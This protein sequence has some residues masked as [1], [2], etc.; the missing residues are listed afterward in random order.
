MSV[1]ALNFFAPSR[2]LSK[3]GLRDEEPRDAER[4]AS[5]KEIHEYRNS[6]GG[7]HRKHSKKRYSIC[8]VEYEDILNRFAQSRRK[9]AN[10]LASLKNQIGHWERTAGVGPVLENTSISD[11]LLIVNSL[12]A[13]AALDQKRNEG[14]SPL[15]TLFQ[16][17]GHPSSKM[18][19]AAP[20]AARR[21]SLAVPK[22]SI[23]Q[24]GRNRSFSTN[25]RF[26]S[27]KTR[28]DSIPA[29]SN[30]QIRRLR[31]ESVS[32]GRPDSSSRLEP[33][34][35]TAQSRRIRR[36]SVKPVPFNAAMPEI[37]ISGPSPDVNQ[38]RHPSRFK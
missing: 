1:A 5:A 16:N 29:L 21:Y 18:A 27:A 37:I 38:R 24:A 17:E 23:D 22:E 32:G 3:S 14:P 30:P 20:T 13:N 12:S 11:F 2:Q 36:F 9:E 19:R 8:D 10:I 15:F 26:S 33:P 34:S 31:S 28:T 35:T 25:V 6:K 4:G 7:G